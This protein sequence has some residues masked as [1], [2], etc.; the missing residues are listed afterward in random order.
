MK[1]LYMLIWLSMVSGYAFAQWVSCPS[2][3]IEPLNS[4]YLVDANTGFAV[5]GNSGIILK[6]A[7][8]GSSWT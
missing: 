3:T 1:K 6:T 7:D 4:V 5:G 2:N 8:K